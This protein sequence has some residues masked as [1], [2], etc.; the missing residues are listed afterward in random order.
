MRRRLLAALVLGLLV[1]TAFVLPVQ[2]YEPT[3]LPVLPAEHFA[4][5]FAA[6]SSLTG[7]TI[8]GTPTEAPHVIESGDTVQLTTTGLAYYDP[9]GNIP[10][11]FEPSTGERYAITPDVGLVRWIGPELAPPPWV[12]D[13]YRPQ[14]ATIGLAAATA[15]TPRDYLYSTYPR[16]APALDAIARCE[17]GWVPTARNP[18]GA[19]GLF[20]FLNTTWKSTPQ[21]LAGYSAFDPFASIDGAVWLYS[22]SGAWPWLAS[23][24]CHHL[25]R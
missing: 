16:I 15:T 11:F 3:D 22:R 10:A 2:A 1:T 25:I 21:G 19:S 4:D 14:P 8:M 12:I 13:A 18:S 9:D 7:G 17:S 23:N 6:L 24:G 20:Q 5:G